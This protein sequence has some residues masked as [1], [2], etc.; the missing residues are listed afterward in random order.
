M[1]PKKQHETPDLFRSHLEQ[2]LN[3]KHP[4]YVLANQI[5]WSVFDQKL[6]T[7]YVEDKGRPGKP[8]R[9]MVGLHYLKYTFNES[10]ESVLVTISKIS[11]TCFTKLSDSS[12]L[13]NF[14]K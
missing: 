9:L 1:K 7:T 5:D 12:S 10:D 3:P 4:L 13:S 6:G 14:L 8:T 2:I 11:D